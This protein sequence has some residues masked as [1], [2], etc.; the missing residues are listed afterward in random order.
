MRSTL[1]YLLATSIILIAWTGCKAN[2]H[3]SEQRAAL[4]LPMNDQKT[5]VTKVIYERPAAEVDKTYSAVA[6][7]VQ[8]IPEDYF[9][10]VAFEEEIVKDISQFDYEVRNDLGFPRI[11]Y[12]LHSY[13]ETIKEYANRYNFDWR[14]ILA[15]MNQESRFRIQAVSH[16]GAYGLMQIMPMTGMDVSVALGI[17]DF[18][19]PKDNIAGGVYY[20][21]RVR[22]LFDEPTDMIDADS[23]PDDDDIIR[24]S[25]AAYNAGPTR[26]RDAQQL[27]VYLGLNPYRWQVIRDLL[28]MLSRQ[29]Y[30]LHRYVWESGR[31]EGGYFH[32]WPE[33]VN[34]VDNV[35]G[36][37]T[38]YRLIFE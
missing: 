30:T 34:Y 17:D 22:S 27:A 12:I 18:Q 29:Y 9:V 13:E 4:F 1:R 2:I 38:Y 28:P 37:Y 20:L 5:P 15:V 10:D 26:V 6:Q 16:R 24:L 19:Q 11:Q 23:Q 3:L 14:L 35:M 8:I 36:Y 25:L 33:T 32:G 7:S 21:W 31:P